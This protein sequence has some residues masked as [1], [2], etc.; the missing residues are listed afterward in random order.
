MREEFYEESAII[1]NQKSASAKYSILSTIAVISFI[2]AG[3]F[4]YRIFMTFDWGEGSLIFN[5]IFTL[6]PIILF[7]AV[8]IVLNVFKKRF[9]ID[10]DYTIV[11]GSI[12]FSKVIKNKKRVFISIF[13]ARD[14]DTIGKLGSNTFMK[15]MQMVEV[16]KMIL[17]SNRVPSDGMDFYYFAVASKGVRTLY[18]LECSKKFIQIVLQYSRRGILDEDMK[19]DIS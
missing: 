19:N 18:V 11:T 13:D 16:K 15:Y 6:G 2:C 1:Q 14:I 4:A 8:G 5:L 12:R 9:Y 17:T 7:I 10:Y 3:F